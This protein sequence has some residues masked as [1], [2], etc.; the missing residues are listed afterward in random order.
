MKIPVLFLP[1][2]NFYTHPASRKGKENG[3]EKNNIFL[4]FQLL[5]FN[6]KKKETVKTMIIVQKV[7]SLF[8]KGMDLFACW[9]NSDFFQSGGYL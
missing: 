6:G 2:W 3:L 9:D 8:P 4:H 7:F 1:G 5:P